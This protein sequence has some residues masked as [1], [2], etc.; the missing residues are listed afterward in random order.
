MKLL[1]SSKFNL[2]RCNLVLIRRYIN[3]PLFKTPYG[4]NFTCLFKI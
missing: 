3:I 4:I 1:F 2:E